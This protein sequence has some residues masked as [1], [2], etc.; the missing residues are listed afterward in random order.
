[1]ESSSFFL[2]RWLKALGQKLN[3]LIA[4]KV[5]NSPEIDLNEEKNHIEKFPMVNTNES[6]KLLPLIDEELT[7]ISQNNTNINNSFLSRVSPI[8]KLSECPQLNTKRGRE[9]EIIF[10]NDKLYDNNLSLCRKNVEE[11]IIRRNFLELS[12]QLKQNNQ[13]QNEENHF[14]SNNTK[15]LNRKIIEKKNSTSIKKNDAD[16]DNFMI[17]YDKR[18]KMLE[19]YF[20]K[21]KSKYFHNKSFEFNHEKIEKLKN[22]LNRKKQFFEKDKCLYQINNFSNNF[23]DDTRSFSLNSNNNILLL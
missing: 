17:Q 23:E 11:N 8:K 22:E 14:L 10:D 6:N 9:E 4:Y 15:I 19:D 12:N 5:E 13:N 21:N 7:T 1:M 20:K 16:K 18:K 2:G 3:E